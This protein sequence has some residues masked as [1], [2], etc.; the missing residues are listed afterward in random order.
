[1]RCEGVVESVS[2]FGDAS[3]EP[4][5]HLERRHLA[6]GPEPERNQVV[7]QPAVLPEGVEDVVMPM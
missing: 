7:S 3:E 5:L 6:V 1:M 2:T 4:P